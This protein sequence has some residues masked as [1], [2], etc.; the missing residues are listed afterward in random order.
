MNGTPHA[1]IADFVFDGEAVRRSAAV[2]ID[3]PNITEVL[4]A[5]EL[6]AAIPTR[7][8]RNGAWLAPGFIDTQVN[9]GGD[10]LFNDEPTVDGIRT[11]AAAHRRFG[12]TAMLPT[13]ISD[14][15]EKTG[16]AL[17]AVSDMVGSDPSIL[18]IHLE[19]P[20]LSPEKP[21]Y[22]RCNIFGIRSQRTSR[23]WRVR[24]R[25]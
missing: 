19:G 21:G 2:V 13:L 11:I 6:S 14:T 3:G 7:T 22:T 24:R 18:G 23:H 9:G 10:V 17:S 16:L 20:F 4:P 15:P 25:V 5:S 12:T 8:L 1:L